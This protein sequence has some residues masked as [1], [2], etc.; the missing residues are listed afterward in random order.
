MLFFIIHRLKGTFTEENLEEYGGMMTYIGYHK[1]YTYTV[2]YGETVEE[3]RA[4]EFVDLLNK[5]ISNVLPYF[6]YVR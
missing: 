5:Y 4:I 2:E 1:G 3:A 6:E